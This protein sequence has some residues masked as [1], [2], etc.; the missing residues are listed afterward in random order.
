MKPHKLP[1]Q[2]DITDVAIP[3]G[4]IRLI[5]LTD[6]NRPAVVEMALR[7]YLGE[8]CQGC[9]KTF[10]TLEDMEGSVWWPWEK[11]KIAHKECW[12]KHKGMDE[13]A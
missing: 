12:D 3:G 5:E 7:T 9:H 8:E 6:E 4:T 11:G 13:N 10:E 2:E 1:R